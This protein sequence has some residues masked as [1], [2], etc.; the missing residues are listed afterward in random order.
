MVKVPII[1]LKVHVYSLRLE[2]MHDC[3]LFGC[4]WVWLPSPD[5]EQYQYRSYLSRQVVFRLAIDD[6]SL[7]KSQAGMRKSVD[8]DR[9][10]WFLWILMKT[11]DL[12]ENC[13]FCIFWSKTTIFAD[14][15]QKLRFLWILTKDHGFCRF[16]VP[17]DS[18]QDHMIWF[19]YCVPNWLLSKPFD[20][21]L[22]L[23]T[24]LTPFKTI[25]PHFCIVYPSYSFQD[26]FT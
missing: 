11:A 13:D 14:F 24:Q 19:L 22:S 7:L 15:N 26:H 21:I 16:C 25:W 9:K 6:V 17:I 1:Y 4:L 18:F 10:P 12:T 2:R 20:L 8:F 23:C 5:N 3:L